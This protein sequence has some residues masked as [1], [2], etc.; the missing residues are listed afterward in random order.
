M[1]HNGDM[2]DSRIVTLSWY[3]GSGDSQN[4]IKYQDFDV[5][6]SQINLE[7]WVQHFQL[8]LFLPVW[9]NNKILKKICKRKI[10]SL[11]QM[12]QM[13]KIW[14]VQPLGPTQNMSKKGCN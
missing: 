7:F 14:R 13:L 1:W 5:G 3:L 11:V 12:D 6:V 10:H 2:K 4:R 9:K 8:C